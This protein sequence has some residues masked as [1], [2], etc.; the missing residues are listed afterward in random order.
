MDA[1][2]DDIPLELS[3]VVGEVC[4]VFEASGDRVGVFDV[5]AGVDVIPK[6]GL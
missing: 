2:S 6:D 4:L 3:W 5:K 1:S